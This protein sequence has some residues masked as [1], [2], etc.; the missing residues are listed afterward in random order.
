MESLNYPPRLE[1]AL[2]RLRSSVELSAPSLADPADNMVIFSSIRN[3]PQTNFYQDETLA[4]DDSDSSADVDPEQQPPHIGKS[5]FHIT[6]PPQK[7]R[8]PMKNARRTPSRPTPKHRLRHDDSQIQFE[9]ILSS[10]PRLHK[11]ESQVL[12]ERQKEIM[13]RQR[14]ESR[15]FSDVSAHSPSQPAEMS[16]KP[17]HKDQLDSPSGDDLPNTISRTPL[18]NLASM[19]PM[20]AFLGSSPT[21]NARNRSQQIMSDDTNVATPNAVRTVQITDDLDELASSPPEF[22]R[23]AFAESAVHQDTARSLRNHVVSNKDA[24]KDYSMSFDD[25]STIDDE[26][27]ALCEAPT[28]QDE[29]PTELELT[30]VPSSTI[31]VQLNAQLVADLDAHSG[32]QAV[33]ESGQPSSQAAGRNGTQRSDT[34]RIGDSFESNPATQEQG[35]ETPSTRQ[36]RRSTRLSASAASSPAKPSGTKKKRGRPRKNLAPPVEESRIEET[37]IEETK[38][39]GK[40]EPSQNENIASVDDCIVLATAP[41]KSSKRKKASQSQDPPSESQS[42]IPESQS[43]RSGRKRSRRQSTASQLSVT[44]AQTEEILVNDT[45]APKRARKSLSQDVSEANVPPPPARRLSHVQVSPR[46]SLSTRAPSAGPDEN[47]NSMCVAGAPALVHLDQVS[48]VGEQKAK[49]SAAP[50]LHGDTA[51]TTLESRPSSQASAAGGNNN[52]VASRSLAERVILTPKSI[53]ERLRRTISDLKDMVL[54]RDEERELDDVMFDLRREVH[55]A[56]RRG[57]EGENAGRK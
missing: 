44:E 4:F 38:V 32:S 37:R 50:Q 57:E 23:A 20:D 12:T 48:P 9:P 17:Q 28:S 3:I 16:P 55:A 11:Q 19:G 53:M 40:V 15:L 5:P 18:K 26:L 56:G 46:P 29:F 39:E 45:P 43:K 10:P 36:T 41:L 27:A 21:P 49:A 24:A 7:S 47:E 30:E 8:S 1:K 42:I 6:K 33:E 25:G 2:Q 14:A 51:S 31:E 35:E 54:G 34:S 52:G 22:K 13:E